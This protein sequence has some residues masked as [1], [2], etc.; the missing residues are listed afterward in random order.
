MELLFS[1]LYSL[2]FNINLS[3]FPQ[4]IFGS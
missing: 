4:S 3:L 2:K 1:D